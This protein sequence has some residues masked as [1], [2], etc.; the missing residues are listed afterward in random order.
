MPLVHDPSLDGHT[1]QVR[2]TYETAQTALQDLSTGRGLESAADDPLPADV[3]A[4][5]AAFT[6]L[7]QEEHGGTATLHPVQ[8]FRY[9]NDTLID[10]WTSGEDPGSDPVQISQTITVAGTDGIY[11]EVRQWIA[12]L[13][14]GG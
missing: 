10:G 7:W 12:R 5:Q 14:R 3:A 1:A 11:I 9:V 6:Q 4:A 2:A 13:E 8:Y